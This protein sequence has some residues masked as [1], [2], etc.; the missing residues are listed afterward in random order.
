MLEVSPEDLSFVRGGVQVTGAPERR[1]ELAEIAQAAA[2]GIGLP[3]G[4]RGLKDDTD[5]QAEVSAIPFAASVA[6]VTV[7]R[8]TG[9][10]KLDRL[11]VVDDIGTVVNP[12]IVY[13]QIEGGLAQGVAESL[14]EH[15]E[16]DENGQPLTA[17]LQDY[18]M[19]TAH[20]LPSFELD[21]T[22]TPTPY[23]P[24][25]AKGVGES[26]CV[27]AP[28]AVT[29]AVLDALAPFG[30]TD[31]SMPF[32]EQKVWRALRSAGALS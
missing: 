9:R 21:L 27:S 1:L 6:V 12:L 14:Y 3:E 16:W 20:M 17:T 25:G 31:I 4:E 11:I 32:T 18:A 26:G 13:G 5:F 30:I 23:N 29:N 24:I 28:P 10:V 2:E 15:L 7:E 8:E 19:P 22:I